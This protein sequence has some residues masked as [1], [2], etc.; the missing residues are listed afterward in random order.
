M[1]NKL[2][3][4]KLDDIFQ[5]DWKKQLHLTFAEAMVSY[6]QLTPSEQLKGSVGIFCHG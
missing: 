6:S 1:P 4:L 5:A 2:N 3:K